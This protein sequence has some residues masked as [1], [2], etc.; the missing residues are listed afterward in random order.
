MVVGGGGGT[1]V[2]VTVEP[3]SIVTVSSPELSPHPQS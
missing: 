3:E 2:V 1:V